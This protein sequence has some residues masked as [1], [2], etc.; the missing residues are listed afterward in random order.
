MKSE[1]EALLM[2]TAS[3]LCGM[4]HGSER[5][6]GEA[7]R[8]RIEQS[9]SETTLFDANTHR[10]DLPEMHPTHTLLFVDLPAAPYGLTLNN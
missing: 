1:K 7:G 5:R 6:Q 3:A 2:P 9:C 10:D 4:K 8:E